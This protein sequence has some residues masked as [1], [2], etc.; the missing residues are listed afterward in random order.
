MHHKQDSAHCSPPLP[1]LLALPSVVGTYR[2]R[3]AFHRGTLL[4]AAGG[5]GPSQPLT[6]AQTAEGIWGDRAELV[7]GVGRGTH[8]PQDAGPTL[9]PHSGSVRGD[10]CTMPGQKTRV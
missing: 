6:T 4:T 2:S 5:W 8:L 3:G 9:G 10:S 1:A 7:G